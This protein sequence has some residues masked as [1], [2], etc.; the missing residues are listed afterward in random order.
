MMQFVMSGGFF[1][2]AVLLLGIATLAFN[3]LYLAKGSPTGGR[4]RIGWLLVATLCVG[5]MG[6]GVGLYEAA[7][8]LP[9]MTPGQLGKVLGIASTCLALAAGISA[10]N[11]LLLGFQ[12][13]PASAE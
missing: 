8:K 2:I 7:M 10:V 3:G 11:A 13:P 1:S 5:L 4:Q 9:N 6:T 12:R